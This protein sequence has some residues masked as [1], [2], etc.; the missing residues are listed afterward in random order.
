M[1]V[2]E[3]VNSLIIKW[4]EESIAIEDPT[5]EFGLNAPALRPVHP[6]RFPRR[7][8]TWERMWLVR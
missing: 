8:E 1:L 4:E 3:L 2:N 7:A 6:Q 5:A